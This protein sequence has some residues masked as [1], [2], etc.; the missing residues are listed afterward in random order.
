MFPKT[1]CVHP[2][3][4]CLSTNQSACESCWSDT[5]VPYLM[6]I[7]GQNG[8]CRQSCDP[9]YTSNGSKD[10]ICTKCDVS[11]ATCVDNGVLGDRSRC[12]TCAK[13]YDYRYSPLQQCLK[14][15]SNGF[16]QSSP[17][18]CSLCSPTCATCDRSASNCTSCSIQS[19]QYRYLYDFQC[20]ESCPPGFTNVGATC[21]KCDSK[22]AT[23]RNST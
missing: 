17:F 19:P 13:S 11:C 15:C 21:Q 8:Q 4:S 7:S 22:C 10:K 2:C 14:S 3:K 1:P 6:K 18:I 9:G 20:I 12:I 23:C 16:Y 5:G